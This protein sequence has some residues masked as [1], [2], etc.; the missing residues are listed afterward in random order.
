[1]GEHLPFARSIRSA[2]RIHC[3]Y[4]GLTAKGF[5]GSPHQLWILD[6]GRVDANLIRAREQQGTYVLDATHTAANRKR[7]ENLLGGHAHHIDH[8]RSAV[9]RSSD[10]EKADLVRSLAVV[11]GSNL[12]WITSVAQLDETHTLFHA[13]GVHI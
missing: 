6:G 2:P 11:F 10:I 7:Q 13:P 1:V 12:D 8:C 9:G 5:R 3:N 4:D